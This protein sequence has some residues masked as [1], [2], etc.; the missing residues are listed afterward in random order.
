MDG[1]SAELTPSAVVERR[2]HVLHS[3]LVV[4]TPVAEAPPAS[5]EPVPGALLP[6]GTLGGVWHRQTL[7]FPF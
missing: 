3:G 7:P 1:F 2:A 5:S 6:L 4:T